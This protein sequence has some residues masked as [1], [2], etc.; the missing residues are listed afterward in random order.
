MNSQS[1]TLRPAEPSDLAAVTRL[2]V[3]AKLPADGL[4]EQFGPSYV[5]ATMGS[6][7]VGAEGI[8]RYG[9]TGLLR[10]AVV[11]DRWRG[12]G[13]G[14]RLTRNRLAWAKEQ[15]IRELWLLTTTA[16]DWF[17]RYGFLPADRAAAPAAMQESRE[18]RDACPASATAMRLPLSPEIHP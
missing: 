13:I 4:D 7:V 6:E 5:I 9:D 3:T 11:S 17:T 1:L 14:D 12:R 15:Q 8:E 10:S 16:E 18:F 2:L